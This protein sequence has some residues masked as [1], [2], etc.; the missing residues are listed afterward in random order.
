MVD[1]EVK[2]EGNVI[3][4]TIVD[5]TATGTVCYQWRLPSLV[6]VNNFIE[7]P[8][9]LVPILTDTI[10]MFFCVCCRIEESLRQTLVGDP[11]T[12]TSPV[13]EEEL[14]EEH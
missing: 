7:W 8:I 4:A 9:I 10:L 6:V 11:D 3:D 5:Y 14:K 13:D 2:V 12:D 1:V